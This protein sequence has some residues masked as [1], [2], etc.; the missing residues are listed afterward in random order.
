MNVPVLPKVLFHIYITPHQDLS[1]CLTDT[2]LL[3]RMAMILQNVKL[4]KGEI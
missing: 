2:I 3:C 4:T 1:L